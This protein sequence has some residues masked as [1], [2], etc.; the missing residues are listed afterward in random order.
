MSGLYVSQSRSEEEF[1][2]LYDDT[3]KVEIHEQSPPYSNYPWFGILDPIT[4]EH[5]GP[6]Y[7]NGPVIN[8]NWYGITSSST[9]FGTEIS[10]I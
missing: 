8:Q 9:L 4:N 3:V 7:T 10:E 1:K 5:I 6:T 2:L